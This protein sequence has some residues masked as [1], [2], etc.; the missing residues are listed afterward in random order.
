MDRKIGR[1]VA[2]KLSTWESTSDRNETG[3]KVTKFP[4][5]HAR[6]HSLEPSTEP[7]SIDKTDSPNGYVNTMG[8]PIRQP[9]GA[10]LA[11][12]NEDRFS[13]M[14]EMTRKIY[15]SNAALNS[16]I[17]D[18]L[19]DLGSLAYTHKD[20]HNALVHLGQINKDSKQ[21]TQDM[22]HSVQDGLH[23]IE[24]CLSSIK[25]TQKVLT[26]IADSMLDSLQHV[27]RRFDEKVV[28]N[29]E[30]SGI[31]SIFQKLAGVEQLIRQTTK[32]E[33]DT[34]RHDEGL[35]QLKT[36]IDQVQKQVAAISAAD[37][38]STH[39]D[40]KLED[41]KQWL[42]SREPASVWKETA[43]RLACVETQVNQQKGQDKLKLDQQKEIL[44]ELEAIRSAVYDASPKAGE[45]DASSAALENLTAQTSEVVSLLEESRKEKTIVS[46]RLGVIEQLVQSR[47]QSEGQSEILQAIDELK[48]LVAARP[49]DTMQEIKDIVSQAQAQITKQL[50][51][52]FDTIEKTAGPGQP[53]TKDKLDSILA[54]L[55]LFEKP[56]EDKAV[57]ADIKE[58]KTLVNTLNTD[59]DS[60]SDKLGAIQEHVQQLSANTGRHDDLRAGLDKLTATME[61]AIE[62]VNDQP[63][64][65]EVPENVIAHI[66]SQVQSNETLLA[67]LTIQD[68]LLKEMNGMWQQRSTESSVVGP[69]QEIARK[70]TQVQEAVY[71]LGSEEHKVQAAD[72]AEAASILKREQQAWQGQRD[73]LKSE[74]DELQTQKLMLSGQ[75]QALR[76]ELKD[77]VT[78]F[79][80]FE[81]RVVAFEGRLNHSLIERSESLLTSMSSQLAREKPIMPMAPEQNKENGQPVLVPKRSVSL[82]QTNN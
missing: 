46:Q 15:E 47:G 25:E 45:K 42:Q 81:E 55:D 66:A 56:P 82:M 48:Q 60:V 37:A 33:P 62:K 14:M 70:L 77:G 3:P 7:S 71:E 64:V 11:A 12:V 35:E 67:R 22:S 63:R 51:E 50:G 10:K 2:Q 43:E 53:T 18:A 57:V 30:N 4:L 58:L 54:R 16:S 26:A 23:K 65:A 44:A 72:L 52:H 49:Q 41:L 76:Q 79:A 8:S 21:L 29:S 36:K 38:N 40:R 28:L 69:M 19:L 68:D 73:Q 32:H 5:R 31:S 6:A 39:V 27:D 34:S 80:A 1:N 78:E 61:S 75:V 20:N 74:I 9:F 17:K 59:A 13:E 24:S